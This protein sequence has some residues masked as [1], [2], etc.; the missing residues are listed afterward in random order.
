MKKPTITAGGGWFLMRHATL[1]SPKVHRIAQA[2]YDTDTKIDTQID[3]KF[4]IDERINITIGALCRVWSWGNR[5]ADAQ[6]RIDH[7]TADTVDKVSG[8]DG[9]CDAMVAVG[10]AEID[11]NGI[12]LPH[13][14]EHNN[15]IDKADH[16]SGEPEDVIVDNTDNVS[17]V[18]N[19]SLS[20]T[21]NAPKK[22]QRERERE[23]K[24]TISIDPAKKKRI[25]PADVEA[26]YRAYP[27]KVAKHQ[28]CKAIEKAI[29]SG[30]DPAE[31]LRLTLAFASTNPTRG[32]KAAG[33]DNFCPYPS[34][35]FNQKRFKDDDVVRIAD[36]LDGP[37]ALAAPAATPVT[38]VAD[39]TEWHQAALEKFADDVKAA[40]QWWDKFA[41][42][43]GVISRARVRNS[44]QQHSDAGAFKVAVYE[45]FCY[46]A[47]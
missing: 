43:V 5:Y 36:G 4:S 3:T 41:R 44:V 29:K 39:L 31:L 19:A 9:F 2:L 14:R 17:I 16:P 11:D 47:H 13:F 21:D 24:N 38:T 20:I 1:D 45:G 33:E 10:W 42:D 26:I 7:A 23:R 30:C 25:N 18:D 8:I 46:D 22:G 34:T 6:D 12:T 32:A 37:G 35:W 15:P 28:G 27:R 40:P